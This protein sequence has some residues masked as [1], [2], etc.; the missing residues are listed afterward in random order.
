MMSGVE[1]I[2]GRKIEKSVVELLWN[3]TVAHK[4]SFK[5][6]DEI[7]HELYQNLRRL[8]YE[9]KIYGETPKDILDPDFLSNF[10]KYN[11]AFIV[12][13]G[14]YMIIDTMLHIKVPKEK[15]YEVLQAVGVEVIDA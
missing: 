2:V 8:T 9:S 14:V 13:S 6:D 10:E 11:E 3:A 12:R 1:S 15:L 7:R 4:A 5:L